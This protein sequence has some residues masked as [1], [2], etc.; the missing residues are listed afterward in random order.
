[1]IISVKIKNL[2][3]WKWEHK[4]T[5]SSGINI[6]DWKYGV[7]KSSLLVDAFQLV[8][9]NTARAS[10]ENIITKWEDEAEVELIW[11]TPE[12]EKYK[13]YWYHKLK[14]TIQTIDEK[15]K[16][17]K[18][19]QKP[20]KTI[21]EVQEF[22]TD[23]NEYVK[24]YKSPEQILGIPYNIASKTF[25]IKQNDIDSF[26]KAGP[27]EK[28]DIIANSFNISILFQ[29]WD[30]AS[31]KLKKVLIEKNLLLND[32]KDINVADFDRIEELKLLK[33]NNEKEIKELNEKEQLISKRREEIRDLLT[34]YNLVLENRQRIWENTRLINSLRQVDL[35]SHEKEI[36]SIKL[37]LEKESTSEIE[38]IESELA[39]NK[40]KRSHLQEIYTSKISEIE[41]IKNIKL[42]GIL[43]E[44]NELQQKYNETKVINGER[45][46]EEYIKQLSMLSWDELIT[47]YQEKNIIYQWLEQTKQVLIHRLNTNKS[48]IEKIWNL[49]ESTCPTCYRWL[50]QK[51]KQIVISKFI[52]EKQ[53]IEKEI[54]TNTLNIEQIVKELQTLSFQIEE[55]QS[56]NKFLKNQ[57]YGILGKKKL[58]EYNQVKE[59][60]DRKISK[61]KEQYEK[62]IAD[63]TT[64][65][66][67]LQDKYEQLTK[68][69]KIKEY[70]EIL[71]A[72]ETKT[73][74]VEWR[75]YTALEIKTTINVLEDQ[76]IDLNKN[77]TKLL[78]ELK[79][80]TEQEESYI[81]EIN[82]ELSK[83]LIELEILQTK[84]QTKQEDLYSLNTQLTNLLNLQERYEKVKEK[85]QIYNEQLER[86]EK[87]S[88]IFS[89][90][91]Q[92]KIII[93]KIIIPQLELKTN[94]ILNNI[95]DGKY[96]VSFNLT[97]ITQEWKES[98]K[99]TFDIIVYQDWIEQIYD[100]LSGG[101]QM[102]INYAIRLGITECLNELFWKQTS[103]ILILD[104]AFNAIDSDTSEEQILKSIKETSKLY[105]QVFI[106]T[107]VSELKDWLQW[108]S[109]IYSIVKDG[110][111]SYLEK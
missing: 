62:E 55:L 100:S 10:F 50:S 7:G 108:V 107:H 80:N 23:E 91:W 48:I 110:K 2:A 5:Y 76:L 69:S 47:K 96:Q 17:I 16:K 98:K 29:I 103:D 95:T 22:N 72:L 73:F 40:W 42:R 56:L 81:N 89:R 105:K 111:Y 65:L 109:T 71:K 1:M 60:E 27:T 52:K 33:I 78:K 104:E 6:L 87:I 70:K 28:Y 83:N 59:D 25:L 79:I 12:W 38:K 106:I 102:N 21:W 9:T 101:E 20:W 46:T 13:F 92:P 11:Q 44:L 61:I 45:F 99:N 97:N 34:K 24:S 64:Y 51:E 35:I 57:E 93:E 18:K 19:I 31:E 32:L 43:S 67:S 41:W 36:E 30:K 37:L 82:N 68:K 8:M 4:I 15:T 3:R 66:V 53:E 88:S 39:I 74:L 58:E 26:S 14:K 49:T 54:T 90:K 94:T 84:R 86:L 85:I 75:I 63:I 77:I